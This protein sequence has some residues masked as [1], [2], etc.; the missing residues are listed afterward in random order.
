MNANYAFLERFS[1]LLE[2]ADYW[3]SDYSHMKIV[4]ITSEHAREIATLAVNAGKAR[5]ALATLCTGDLE[6]GMTRMWQA[7]ADDA[8][9]DVCVTR[10]RE[11]VVSWLAGRLGAPVNLDNGQ[12]LLDYPVDN[13]LPTA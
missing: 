5:L 10:D 11:S 4:G 1:H 7:L 13:P 9:W 3:F 2:S 6:F 8:H 12:L